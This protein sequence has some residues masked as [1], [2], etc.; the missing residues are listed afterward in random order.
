MS[1]IL[2]VTDAEYYA[3]PGKDPTLSASIAKLLIEC[4]SRAWLH[5]PRLGGVPTKSTAAMNSGT[6]IDEILTT[7]GQRIRVIESATDAKGNVVHFPRNKKLAN[8]REQILR[9]EEA[10]H[11][12]CLS[13]ELESAKDV[14][15]AV[16]AKARKMR[17]PIDGG[18]NQLAL[19]WTETADDGTPVE[20]RC[21]MDVFHRPTGV[22]QDIKRLANVSAGGCR[23][24]FR[25]FSYDL[26]GA[27]YVSAVESCFP[28]LQGRARFQLIC[29][30]ESEPYPLTPVDLRGS[31]L[32]LGR[33]KWRRA[34]NLWA[35]LMREKPNGDWPDYVDKPITIEPSSWELE[36]ETFKAEEMK[37]D[38]AI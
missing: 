22:I 10:G 9:I 7:D 30:E 26:Q 20:C 16:I 2:N 37:Y 18:R 13:H 5:H 14:A 32:E 19:S 35:R 36:E 12:A 33:M 28:D 1:E 21:K 25:Q 8:T 17:C 15:R 23:R 34:V 31:M 3:D 38:Q 6:L 27:A 29:T 24:A 11:I 4:P